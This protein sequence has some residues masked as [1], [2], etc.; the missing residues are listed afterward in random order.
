MKSEKVSTD[1]KPVTR[2]KKSSAAA[3]TA[4]PKVASHR[5]SKV[6]VPPAPVAESTAAAMLPVKTEQI[7]VTPV[8]PKA[9]APKAVVPPT[10]APVAATVKSAEPSQ[11]DIACLAHSYWVERNYAHGFA[12]EDWLRAE[13]ALTTVSAKAMSAAS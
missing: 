10:P 2:T 13:K 11:E 6:S 1:S 4:T 9:V 3:K 5:H 12:E 7:Q 8:V